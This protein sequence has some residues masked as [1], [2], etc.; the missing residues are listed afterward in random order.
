MPASA[1]Y[2]VARAQA[3]LGAVRRDGTPDPAAAAARGERMP[4]NRADVA[5]PGTRLQA[6][7]TDAAAALRVGD[8][9]GAD[10]VLAEAGG[11]L[12]SALVRFDDRNRPSA[13]AIGERASRA[14]S[15]GGSGMSPSTG[16][17]VL[18]R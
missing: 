11:S 17:G 2:L 9:R 15:Y 13:V 4:D 10:R 5:I 6:Q 14:S 1:Q 3:V 7:L 12:R 8:L 16:T 18:S